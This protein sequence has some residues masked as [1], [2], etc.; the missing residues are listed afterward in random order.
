[1]NYIRQYLAQKVWEAI[2]THKKRGLANMTSQ[3]I[4][5]LPK[6]YLQTLPGWE[7]EKYWNYLP[8]VLQNSQLKN[9]LYCLEHP[10]LNSSVDFGDCGD[11][12]PVRKINCPTCKNGK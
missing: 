5:Y 2:E 1:M 9:Y 11:C 8:K 6:K 10:L 4:S 3:Q 7:L 12:P